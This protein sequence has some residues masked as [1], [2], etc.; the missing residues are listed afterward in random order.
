MWRKAHPVEQRKA[1]LRYRKS[2][3]NLDRCRAWEKANPE[4][5]RAHAAV[6]RALKSGK[7]VKPRLC[8]TC[9]KR[10][11]LQSHHEDYSKPLEVDWICASCHNGIHR[12]I[13]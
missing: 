1:E 11:K 2:K 7:L 13:A 4:K 10:R 12:E 8:E 6:A 5:K 3:A 9:E